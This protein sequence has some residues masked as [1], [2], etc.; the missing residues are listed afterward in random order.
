LGDTGQLCEHQRNLLYGGLPP[1]PLDAAEAI[2]RVRELANSHGWEPMRQTDKV[3]FEW[4]D[5]GNPIAWCAWCQ[6]THELTAR[7][8]ASTWTCAEGAAIDAVIREQLAAAVARSSAVEE[9][10]SEKEQR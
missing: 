9:T 5:N 2:G 3:K 1:L 6:M 10:P 7:V 4:S 8:D